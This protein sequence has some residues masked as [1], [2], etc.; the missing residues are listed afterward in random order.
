MSKKIVDPMTHH[1]VVKRCWF[2]QV[3]TRPGQKP[4]EEKVPRYLPVLINTQKHS[5]PNIQPEDWSFEDTCG[6]PNFEWPEY[7]SE[8]TRHK[9]QG[10]AN[11]G[12]SITE[13]FEQ[14]YG[15]KCDDKVKDVADNAPRDLRVGDVI[16]MGISSITKNGVTFNGCNI[17]QTVTSSVNL[18]RY[19]NFKKFLPTGDVPLKILS[20]TPSKIV[21]DPIQP[22]IDQWLLQ[23][24]ADPM[25]QRMVGAPQTVTV[26]G[27]QLTKGG[28]IGK[29]VIPT[30]SE[31]VGEDYCI[32]AF[33]PGSQIVLNI[34][35]DFEQWIDKSVE[36]FV[37]N[38]IPKPNTT[39][40]MSLVCSRK[41]YLEFQGNINTIAMFKMWCDSGNGGKSGKEWEKITQIEHVGYVTNVLNSSN[42]CGVFVEIPKLQITGLVPTPAKELCDY[43]PGQEVRITIEDMVEPTSFDKTTEQLVHDIPYE[44]VDGI[45]TSCRL[46]TILKFVQ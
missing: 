13:A 22:L 40:G 10:A 43:K 36:A 16:K 21:V 7:T 29:A 11:R 14:A 39:N 32:D 42:V 25:M 46:K 23:R 38:Y 2:T 20:I 35:H 8:K 5:A 6:N 28:F 3:V 31:W 33:I 12:K 45:L 19:P 41:K 24:I 34:E 1:A 37:T 18:W 26:K 27:L 4:K 30:V 44:I 17:K 15:I 9:M